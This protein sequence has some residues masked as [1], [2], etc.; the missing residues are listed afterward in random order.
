MEYPHVFAAIGRRPE[1]VGPQ[2]TNFREDFFCF[3]KR[4]RHQPLPMR[5]RNHAHEAFSYALIGGSKEFVKNAGS[6]EDFNV[7]PFCRHDQVRSKACVSDAAP[8]IG[9]NEPAFRSDA[10]WLSI[11]LR[12]HNQVAQILVSKNSARLCGLGW[13]GK[14]PL[15]VSRREWMERYGNQP[16]ADPGTAQL[17]TTSDRTA[18]PA[19]ADAGAPAQRAPG[20]DD[21]GRSD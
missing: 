4:F 7:L 11:L 5:K 9:I 3:G 12:G 1:P 16:A 15:S 2:P 6:G 18:R 21:D 19:F 20:A 8:Q 17:A 13:A 10:I 14:T